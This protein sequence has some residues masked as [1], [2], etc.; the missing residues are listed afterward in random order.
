MM[1]PAERLR[2]HHAKL[3]EQ[4]QREVQQEQYCGSVEGQS[5]ESH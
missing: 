2:I 4:A 3:D 5:S 1:K